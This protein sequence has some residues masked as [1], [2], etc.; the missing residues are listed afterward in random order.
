M[1]CGKAHNCLG[2]ALDFTKKGKVK[3]DMSECIKKTVD[4]FS[5]KTNKIEKTL[6]GEHS[7]VADENCPKLDEEQKQEFHTVTAKGVFVCKRAGLD[8]QM[9]MEFLSTRVKEPDQDDWKN[10]A[11]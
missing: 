6:E 4:N 7:F 3:V 10:C 9:A 11:A 1:K 5:I 2:M 8:I